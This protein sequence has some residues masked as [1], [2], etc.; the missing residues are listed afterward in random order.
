MGLTELEI[1]ESNKNYNRLSILI[2]TTITKITESVNSNLYQMN[3]D[4][5]IEKEISQQLNIKTEYIKTQPT[6]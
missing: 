3:K 6:I 2:G 4:F 1:P 5:S